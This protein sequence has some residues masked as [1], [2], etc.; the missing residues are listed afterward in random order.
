MRFALIISVAAIVAS[1]CS[2]PAD[3]AVIYN[4]S[5]TTTN[6]G[7]AGCVAYC[8]GYTYGGSFSASGTVALTDIGGI[9]EI[10]AASGTVVVTGA[11]AEY[12]GTYV[13]TSIIPDGNFP[14]TTNNGQWVFDNIIPLDQVGGPA[15]QDDKGNAF[16]IWDNG[17]YFSSTIIETVP[18]AQAGFSLAGQGYPSDYLDAQGTFV[19]SAVP[20]PATWAM[21]LL[22]LLGIGF[23]ARG[24]RRKDVVAAA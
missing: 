15:F 7:P 18:D 16:N 5:Y 11:A 12:D 8:S 10:T 22:G 3:A 6:P 14:S 9:Y 13:L 17:P 2:G 1:L 23:M 20:E 24:A 4:W 21:L 19:I